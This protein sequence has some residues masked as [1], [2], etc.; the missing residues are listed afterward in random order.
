MI[1]GPI[2]KFLII[3]LVGNNVD[4]PTPEP[5]CLGG[6]AAMLCMYVVRTGEKM[7]AIHV[8]DVIQSKWPDVPGV[9]SNGSNLIL[10]NS[11]PSIF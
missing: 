1:P 10:T 5:F 11:P 4:A 7:G 3:Y 6:N 2:N 8:F 9:R